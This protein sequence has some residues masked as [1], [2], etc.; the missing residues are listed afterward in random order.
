MLYLPKL[1]TLQLVLVL[2][3]VWQLECHADN[4]ADGKTIWADDI[5]ENLLGMWQML[6][7]QAPVSSTNLID[8]SLS[9]HLPVNSIWHYV[10]MPSVPPSAMCKKVAHGN[11]GVRLEVFQSLRSGVLNK[12]SSHTCGSQ[13][14]PM[15]LSS[16]GSLTLVYIASFVA[17]VRLCASLPTIVKLF[18]LVWWPMV[19]IFLEMGEGDHDFP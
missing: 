10:Y 3:D 13:Y 8:I 17:L 12:T 6:C 15:F 11:T 19:L 5:T 9:P 16:D 4:M 18:I 7:Y 14:F 2:H 1:Y